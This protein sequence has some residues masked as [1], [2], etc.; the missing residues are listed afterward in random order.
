MNFNDFKKI[1]FANYTISK[2][3]PENGMFPIVEFNVGDFCA[4]M[5][6]N[7]TYE[8]AI[9]IA[10]E[11]YQDAK[12]RSI[13]VVGLDEKNNQYAFLKERNDLTPITKTFRCSFSQFPDLKR[14]LFL[15]Q[16][17]R[18]E[19]LTY[20]ELSQRYNQILFLF[21]FMPICIRKNDTPVLTID[22]DKYYVF[23]GWV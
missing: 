15:E 22:G 21:D 11:M 7:V 5:C 19:M 3:N 10:W 17:N 14:C 23:R 4:K 12:R 16:R 9:Q 8:T 18:R 1:C 2:G 20:N 13:T 6:L